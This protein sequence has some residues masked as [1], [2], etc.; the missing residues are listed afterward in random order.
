M[1]SYAAQTIWA[2]LFATLCRSI[3][4]SFHDALRPRF[5]RQHGQSSANVITLSDLFVA[6]LYVELAVC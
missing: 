6:E 4:N 2:A 3:R 1:T 5:K